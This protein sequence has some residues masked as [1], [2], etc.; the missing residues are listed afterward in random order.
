M[1]NKNKILLILV[2]LLAVSFVSA[3]DFV[4]RNESD[5]TQN[6]F[7]VNGTT[8]NLNAD[9]NITAGYFMGDGSLLTNID[10][11]AVSYWT[12]TGTNL[13]YSGGN[14]GIGISNPVTPF[15]VLATS[16]GAIDVL[17]SDSEYILTSR[18]DAGAGD[19][20]Q[21]YIKHNLGGVEIGNLR[22][23][24]GFMDGNVGIGTTSPG[25]TLDVNGSSLRLGSSSQSA[26][27]MYITA[28][29]TASSPARTAMVEMFGYEG[30]GIGTVYKDVTYSGEEWFS[31][32]PYGGSFN[33]F[34]IGYDASGSQPEYGANAL[35]VVEKTGKVGIG[36][37]PGEA[38]DVSGN[39]N[40]SGD[41][42]LNSGECLST[43]AG[44]AGDYVLK[45]GDTMTGNL[46]LSNGYG[47][48]YNN[49]YKTYEKTYSVNTT[50][51]AILVD[52]TGAAFTPTR[53]Y[54]VKGLII[55]TGTQTG[56]VAYFYGDGTNFHIYKEYEAGTSSNHVEFYLDSGVPKV[57]LYNHASFYSVGV[58]TEENVNKGRVEGSQMF[59]SAN[60]VGAITT[61]SDL[62]IAGDN[63]DSSGAALRI[64]DVANQPVY[65]GSGT[66][67]TA[68]GDN[69]FY[70]TGDIETDQNVYMA[71][72]KYIGISGAERI[73]FD[74]A[75][76][77]E[78]LEA[79]VG[80][81]M[82]PGEALDVSGN[83]NASGDICL[84]DG[85][86]LS[87]AASA[88]GYVP[89]T[90]AT[91]S[92]NLNGKNLTNVNYFGINVTD[93]TTPLQISNDGWISAKNA[94]GDGVVN[95]FK[96]N[97]ENQIEVGA[98]LNIG[99]FEFS[100]DSGLVT[101][102]DMPVTS[103][104]D[105]G[106][107]EGYAFKIDRDNVMTI[108]A[109]SDGAG[110][111]QNKRVGIGTATPANALN[112]VGDANF[113]G[114]VYAATLDTGQGANELYD[115]DQNVLTTSSP[116]F[117]GL[118]MT[119]NVAMG[120]NK[121][122]GLDNG[123]AATDAVT[124]S[125][126]D[127][128]N[129]SAA[130]ESDTLATVTGRGATTATATSFT[131]TANP[132]LTVGNGAIG[133]LKVGGSLISD[134]SGDLTL[135]SDSGEVYIPD[136]VG[137]G[138][139]APNAKLD[140]NGDFR[141]QNN[142]L[143]VDTSGLLSTTAS[144]TPGKAFSETSSQNLVVNGDLE[145]W[146]AGT[147]TLPDGWTK[148]G[149]TISERESTI[150]KTGT[151]SGKFTSTG[152]YSYI[153]QYIPPR[154][155][156]TDSKTYTISFWYNSSSTNTLE[157]VIGFHDGT[158][159]VFTNALTSDDSWHQY[160]R[161]FTAREDRRIMITWWLTTNVADSDDYMYIDDLRL[162]E[163][164]MTFAY[165]D[166]PLSASGNETHY[167][168]L[169]NIGGN[170]GIGTTT[171]VG[172]L[173]V[174]GDGNFTGA[175][176]VDTINTGNGAM[177]LGDDSTID[178]SDTNSI[179]TAD[180]VYDFVASY[181]ATGGTGDI[182]V[183]ITGDTMS[184]NL[185]M[186]SHYITGL[187]NGSAAQDA[188]TYSQLQAI[189]GTM[190]GDYVPYSG[191][192]GSVDLN[193]KNL[194]NVNRLGIGVS[195][196][197]TPLQLAN[198]G[199]ISAK[200]AVGDGT[201][202]MF[203]VNSENQIE[204]GAALNIGSFEFSADSG[205]VTFVD[206]P[207]TADASAGTSESYVFKVDG[208]NIMTIYSES[209][210]MD[211]IQNKRVGI[212]TATP[213]NTLNVV[214]DAN[215]TGAVY[216]ATLDTGQGANELYDMD[217]NV[218]TS[219]SPTF[220]GLTMTGNVAMSGNKITGLADGSAD[221][222]AVTYSQL[223]SVN[224]TVT[225]DYVPY[226]GATK[227]INL[228]VQFLT[229]TGA[230]STGALTSTTINTGQGANELY[231]M[232]QDVLN[233]SSVKFAGINTTSN[234]TMSGNY[235]TGLANGSLPQDAVTKAQLDAVNTTASVA[236]SDPI[237][238]LA[239]SNYYNTTQTD[240]QIVAAN[241]SMKDY[242]DIR[243]TVA[244]LHT[245]DAANIT[246][247]TLDIVRLPTTVQNIVGST[248]LPNT[249]DLIVYGDSDKYYPVQIYGGNQNVMRT[250]KIWRS[251]S[252]LHPADWYSSTHGGGLMLT[253]QG[254][255]GGWGGAIYYDRLE[256][257]TEQYNPT[258]GNAYI[259]THSIGYVFM[260]RG[261]GSGGA[262]YHFASDQSLNGYGTTGPQVA[263][264]TSIKFY[265]NANPSY[266]VYAPAPVSVQDTSRLDGMKRKKQS[267]FD[268]RYI[269][270]VGDTMTGDLAMSGNKIT[271]LAD[272]TA[273]NDAVTYSQLQ[274][275]NTSAAV[276]S[277]PYWT[278]NYSNVAFINKANTFG[279]YNQNFDSGTLFVDAANN[280]VG[281]GIT[282]PYYQLDNRFSNPDIV[283][284]GGGGG[285]WGSDGLRVENVNGTI[286][287]MATLQFRVGDADTHIAAVRRGSNDA[288]LGF[289]F[290]GVEKMRINNN[291]SMTFMTGAA[292][293]EFSTDTNLAGNS[294]L[295]VPTEKAV[296]TYVD[297]AV[298]A[299]VSSGISGTTNYLAKFNSTNSV[300]T[301]S[302]IDDDEGVRIG[303]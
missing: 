298:G 67:T 190:T 194:T 69:D 154:G 82:T 71:D 100:A 78:I 182:Y 60:S 141:I 282:S 161:T 28:T 168:D 249:F 5:S 275:V 50:T 144:N 159:Y 260:L 250:I 218:L 29:N 14:V 41:V 127:A 199:W 245:H 133:Y 105:I 222:D 51:P 136:K 158:S 244:N 252:E 166:K 111:V 22:G 278:G 239:K 19:P 109:Q 121:I 48:N 39:I 119:G 174:I 289:F 184:G 6:Y 62:T 24:I 108:Y 196:P 112:V 118:T 38:L 243:D 189:S 88:S 97:S 238:T 186:G 224:S 104:A 217:Q 191:A 147:S 219:S 86:C 258:V 251:Y 236:E 248:G 192:T 292:I 13:S 303:L 63:L 302:V 266:I 270:T 153:Y 126:L 101:F 259:Y 221:N 125:Q 229:T 225:G 273:N 172:T 274:A 230:V 57:R 200:N 294:D 163:G 65:I 299:G 291:G 72:D 2:L 152:T 46:V 179:P 171:P 49:V 295:A 156:S 262:I 264:N 58:L 198:D 193:S 165:N 103:D 255:F 96:V 132:G 139:N 129:T 18:N 169:Y 263:Y 209:D 106:S 265:D 195:D 276:E 162:F 76:N 253:W 35:F 21:F 284:S 301:S 261:G 213:K 151:Y 203:K 164:P 178:N 277:D 87:A 202:N 170:V 212:G 115:M 149:G 113:T 10:S 68:T 66:A 167:G 234:I 53:S 201:I 64:N 256:E 20:S 102:V 27:T 40:A 70:V 183:D 279:A 208:D 54:K 231:A 31:G 204:V 34:Q 293:N 272:G 92:V 185:S 81:G 160:T 84:N 290:E 246:S 93:P 124:K 75:G 138:T 99:S 26:A 15:G 42:C 123:T 8:G 114:S 228:G 297:D 210:G 150:V 83:I 247:G 267:E 235:I 286:G 33:S 44:A 95:M 45:S 4:I 157:K 240:S 216:G 120:G 287:T 223:Q 90:G 214:G 173:N 107:P 232:N 145:S 241:T 89:Y 47:I 142:A 188:V 94:A 56:A 180:A 36:M 205:L 242:V 257:F 131:S 155:I 116:T 11:S 7:V 135:D 187:G 280:R 288:D 227:A 134:V 16:I 52:S 237:W 79:N 176:T 285:D 300:T 197:T 148:N 177:N 207:V 211:S 80:I 110:G 269:N 61:Y 98:A 254:N 85:T 226:T 23:N 12:M 1:V 43:V 73:V 206:M 181:M 91:G 74:T 283:F 130:I 220:S 296:K 117:A 137:I 9:G 25:S 3:K 122:T 55:S 143:Y 268:N 140:V 17:A 175:L 128:V 37:T 281:I 77:I 32:M 59:L 30:R 146:T 271:G 215:F 233:T